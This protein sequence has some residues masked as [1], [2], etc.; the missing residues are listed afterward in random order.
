MDVVEDF[1]PRPRWAVDKEFQVW[2]EQTMPTALPGFSGGKLP[3]RSKVEEGREEDEEGQEKKTDNEVVKEIFA[4]VPKEAEA[5]GKGVTRNA[6]SVAK[7]LVTKSGLEVGR[8]ICLE[9]AASEL[10]HKWN[11]SQ[12]E[13]VSGE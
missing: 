8:K 6:V 5:V 9:G 3:G 4:A 7:I 10:K 11:C 13:D 1:E 2:P 12:V